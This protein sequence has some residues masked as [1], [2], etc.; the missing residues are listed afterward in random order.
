MHYVNSRHGVRAG[1]SVAAG[2]A[3]PFPST[4]SSGRH[5]STTATTE[6]FHYKA[7]ATDYDGTLAE[8]GNVS[9]ETLAALGRAKLAGRRL[10]LVTGR[11]LDDL[12]R[13]FPDLDVFDL[14][15]AENG[16]L[17]YT[18]RPRPPRERPLASPPPPEL[19]RTLAARGVGPISCGRII[20]ATWE[21]H[22]HVVLE[23]IR[24]L[25]LELEVIFNKGAVMILPS[26]VNKATGLRTAATEL[27]IPVAEIV[28]VGDAEND[29]SLLE[30]CGLGVAVANAVPALKRRAELVT[31]KPRGAGVVEIV[32]QMLMTDFAELPRA[33]SDRVRAAPSSSARLARD[34]GDEA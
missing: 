4:P 7:L 22:Q 30:A 17:L 3:M 27:G 11:E 2:A 5:A 8:D 19:V 23:T 12:V 15:V 29:H 6:P 16:A 28:G 32:D 9:L 14:V 34:D 21:P 1:T 13:V 33:S 24:D 10:I 20:V 26:G 25:G 31:L 18:P